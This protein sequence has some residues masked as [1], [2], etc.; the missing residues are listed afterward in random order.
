MK[1]A[2][3]AAGTFLLMATT[4]AGADVTASSSTDPTLS[5]NTT[6]A[7]VMGS[8]HSGLAALSPGRVR[9]LG[10]P[11]SGNGAATGGSF[12]STSVGRAPYTAA[13]LD[14][15][16]R[17]RGSR[18]WACLTEALY[19]E[20]RGESVEGQFA[21]AEVVLNRVDSPNYPDNICDVVNEGTGR[22]NACQFSYTCDGIPDVVTEPEVHRRLGQIARI[23]MDGGS[24]N[25]TAGA[26]HY[27]ADWVNPDWASAYPQ[28]AQIGV[29]LFYR[30]QC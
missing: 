4:P 11:F 27:H 30:Q 12:S 7:S 23:M 20:A 19:F 25:L 13:E 17:A 26:T 28:T 8:E 1:R 9:S 29:H 22:R 18:Q 2:I 3:C 16:G 14:A 5:L 10:A 21:V 24:R 15:M 6:L